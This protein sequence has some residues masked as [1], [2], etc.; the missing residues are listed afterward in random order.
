MCSGS[1]DFLKFLE[2]ADTI[3]GTVEGR[4]IAPSVCDNSWLLIVNIVIRTYLCRPLPSV[5][6]R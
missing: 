4:H 1:R 5:V 6:S 3:S 2:I